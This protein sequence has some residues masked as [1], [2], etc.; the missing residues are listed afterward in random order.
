MCIRDRVRQGVKETIEKMYKNK[1]NK[2]GTGEKQINKDIS[3]LKK[4]IEE[5]KLIITKADKGNTVV[6]I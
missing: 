3:K 6:I 1:K 5:N 4:K 2:R